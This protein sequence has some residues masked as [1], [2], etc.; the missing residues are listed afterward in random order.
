MTKEPQVEANEVQAPQVE[1]GIKAV[2]DKALESYD[3]LPMLEI[4]FERFARILTTSLR[5]LTSETVDIT[6][7]SFSSS[8]FANCYKD[9][10]FPASI[11][12]F[13]VI[14]WEN[15][16][17]M[18]IDS[19]LAF[20]LV[21]L[22]FG[23]KKN[24]V[25][26][27]APQNTNR[28]YTYIEQALIKQIAEMILSELSSSFDPISPATCVFESLESNPNFAAI[29]RPGDAIII[30]KLNVDLDGK[31]GTID[32]VIPYTTIEPIKDLLQQVFIGE[33][34]GHDAEWET[35]LITQIYAIDMPL[36]AVVVDK[37]MSTVSA[38]SKFK[39][40][41][42]IVLDHRSDED[43]TLLCGNIPLFKCKVGKSNDHVSVSL[44]KPIFRD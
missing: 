15:M 36:S 44:A 27:A 17:L 40:G 35:S 22:L 18:I 6:I 39:V 2:L 37:K 4:V 30:L 20:E 38:V 16:G 31:G 8:R 43:V 19:S 34:F 24:Q 41:S 21:N 28:P 26:A 33:K 3:K 7:K 42:T 1:R 32:V 12:V 13:K 14:E 23:G 29:A 10:T 5:N 11:V 25:V 9:L